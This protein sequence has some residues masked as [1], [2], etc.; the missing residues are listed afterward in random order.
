MR[1]QGG[2]VKI[3]TPIANIIATGGGTSFVSLFCG[4][5]AVEA[6]VAP[7]FD[8]VICNDKQ[9]YLIALWQGVQ[10]GYELPDYV[11][12]EQYYY[13]KD[14]KD[15]DK[16]LT[17][18]CGFPLSFGGAWWHGYARADTHRNY[19]MNA[20]NTLTRDMQTLKKAQFTC[21]DYREVEIPGNSVIYADPP[22]A[23][24]TGYGNE[25]FDSEAF[26]EYMRKLAR[27][28]HTVYISE[29]HAPDDFKCIWEKPLRRTLDR[30]KDNNFWATEKLFIYNGE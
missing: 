22:Y 11:S 9:P 18:L 24:T 4:G 17:G 29:E 13:V 28:G 2:K 7:Y 27:Q 20:K 30:N 19:S 5:C 12:K 16:V 3:S 15:E 25:K 21:L 1:Y 10:N 23:G 8:R 14:H 26:W 6:K